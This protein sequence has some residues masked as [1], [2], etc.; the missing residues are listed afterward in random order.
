[1][2][3]LVNINK[4][5]NKHSKVFQQLLCTAGHF[6][7]HGDVWS[8]CLLKGRIQAFHIHHLQLGDTITN[9]SPSSL[10]PH[11]LLLW[12]VLLI[13]LCLLTGKLAECG[14]DPDT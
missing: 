5:V 3:N 8:V 7:H 9:S 6:Y 10:P 1:M 2:V 4:D 13:K 11:Q 14:S 12:N